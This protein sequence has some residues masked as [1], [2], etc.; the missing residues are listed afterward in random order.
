VASLE[1]WLSNEYIILR[2]GTI[3]AFDSEILPT[4]GRVTAESPASYHYRLDMTEPVLQGYARVGHTRFYVI[5]VD[6]ANEIYLL[7]MR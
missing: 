2:Q 5:L 7:K 3:Y 6:N 1:T 4:N